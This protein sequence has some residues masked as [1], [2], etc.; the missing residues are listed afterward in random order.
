MDSP[1]SKIPTQNV[2]CP[3]AMHPDSSPQGNNPGENEFDFLEIAG[4]LFKGKGKYVILAIVSIAAIAGV[5]YAKSLPNIYKSEILIIPNKKIGGSGGGGAA[6]MANQLGG[7]ASVLGV[8]VGGGKQ[9]NESEVYLAIMR[10]RPFAEYTIKEFNLLPL[11]A[12]EINKIYP[13]TVKLDDAVDMLLDNMAIVKATKELGSGLRISFS[14]KSPELSARIVET[15]V[16]SINRYSQYDTIERAKKDIAMA[17]AQLQQSPLT[18]MQKVIWE[19]VSQKTMEI[20]LAQAQDDFSFRIIEPAVIPK[21]KFKPRRSLIVAGFT[22]IG[23][24]VGILAVLLL[25]R[26]SFQKKSL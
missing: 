19:I 20:I 5:V 21:V 10:T 11:L 12:V 23:F 17:S 16:K 13:D 7:L 25:T 22:G 26:P 24:L 6:S 18:M 1:G 3:F 4:I 8:S 15:L 2:I 9:E 14:S